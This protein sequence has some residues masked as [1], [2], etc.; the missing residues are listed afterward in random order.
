MRRIE[1]GRFARWVALGACF[2]LLAALGG[3]ASAQMPS[4]PNMT[5]KIINNSKAYGL[6]P[7]LSVGQG[8]VDEWMQAYFGVD[9]NGLKTD[10][11][12]RSF[13]YRIYITPTGAGIPPGHSVTLTLPLF[14]QLVTNIVPTQGG[15]VADWWQ[16]G[17]I[18]MFENLATAGAPPA[19]L[20][21]EI[22]NR[23]DQKPLF[24][25][26]ITPPGATVPSCLT[27]TGAVC[28]LSFVQDTSELPLG[29]PFQLVE[30]TLGAVNKAV[31][32]Y[33]LSV[34]NIDIDV[35]YVDSAYMPAMVEP[36]PNSNQIWGWVGVNQTIPKFQNILTGFLAD[37][38]GWPQFIDNRGTEILKIPSPLNVFIADEINTDKLNAPNARSDLTPLPWQPLE[39][40][41]TDYQQCLSTPSTCLAQLPAINQLLAANY[42]NY[43]NN[44]ANPNTGW[45][46][47]AGQGPI[48]ETFNQQI[49][50][51]HGWSPYLTGCTN[52]NGNQVYHTPGYFTP[53]PPPDTTK[54]EAV[55]RDFDAAQVVPAFNPYVEFIHGAKYLNAPNVYAYS[56]DDAVGNLQVDQET[57][58]Y[59]AVGSPKGFPN[60]KPAGPVVQA[61]FGYA[62]TD[63][64]RFVS[65]GICTTTPDIPVDPTF[66]SFVLPGDAHLTTCPVSFVDNLGQSYHYTAKSLPPY[67]LYPAQQQNVVDCTG[68]DANGLA[69]CNSIFGQAVI[70][71]GTGHTVNYLIAGAP[72]QPPP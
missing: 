2:V 1:C 68:N 64:V 13:T 31:I 5:I 39:D 11:F 17:G 70:D 40:L 47:Q 34:K 59:L 14:T 6:Y 32:P 44:Y 36:Y 58:F 62:A 69:W 56:V 46:C 18:R 57:G 19:A 7:V 10:V 71:V 27:D 42:A 22:K 28:E 25:N 15:Q 52:A 65:Y 67:S 60:I 72:P 16:G 49:G 38:P 66:T 20:E 37:F 12:P 41:R 9:R 29:D 61:P 63:R 51:L 30:Y 43:F 8:G 4:V 54:Y 53:G 55:K 3:V 35:S 23:P 26:G 21:S 50:H 45:G 33:Q 24:P 48:A